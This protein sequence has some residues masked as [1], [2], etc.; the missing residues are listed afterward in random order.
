MRKHF[1]WLI[2]IAAPFGLGCGGASQA[3]KPKAAAP[4]PG[5]QADL[6]PEV[7]HV[8]LKKVEPIVKHDPN[9]RTR[10]VSNAEFEYTDPI[11]G[12]MKA[13]GPAIERAFVPLANQR[14]E[15]FRA[16][17]GRY[18][19]DYDEFMKEVVHNKTDPMK[20]PV[21]P[22]KRYEYDEATH[23]VLVTELAEPNQTP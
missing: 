13:F 19:K 2:V 16:T 1:V 11:T 17:N 21:L 6:Q 12:P 22:G 3:S 4:I 5:K 20:I 23:K 18:P 7:A 14:V 15:M 8:P 10:R 9:D